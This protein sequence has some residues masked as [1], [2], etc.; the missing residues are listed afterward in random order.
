MTTPTAPPASGVRSIPVRTAHGTFDVWTRRSGES[1]HIKLLLLHGGPGCTHEYFEVFDSFLPQAGVELYFYDQLGSH[2]SSQPDHADLWEI[3]RFVDEV[4]QVRQALALDGSN[5]FLLGHSWG[6]I[7]AIEYALR[8]QQHLKGLIISNMVWSVPE[9]NRYAEEN[10]LRQLPAGVLAELQAIEAAEDYDNP[11]YMELLIPH[12]YEHHVLRR[13]YAQ[14]PDSVLRAFEH[15]NPKVYIPMQGP[16]ELGARGKLAQ[17]DRRADLSRIQVPTLT[18]GAAHDTMDPQQMA[19]MAKALPR[20]S[21]LH[22][23]NGSHMAMVDDQVVYIQGLID[24]LQR[25]DAQ[26]I[27]EDP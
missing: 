25:V 19:A 17:W 9:Y 20:G 15:L 7:L 21:H 5:F 24:F 18:I 2:H 4:E 10:F 6:G 11:R 14:W 27:R 8:H 16:S 13:P 3:E 1:P 22:C 12:H 23:P 26:A